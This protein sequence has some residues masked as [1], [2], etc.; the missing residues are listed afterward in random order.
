MYGLIIY[1]SIGFVRSKF[2]RIYACGLPIAASTEMTYSGVVASKNYLCK[3]SS[4]ICCWQWSA[5]FLLLTNCSMFNRFSSPAMN[6]RVV[7]FP[8]F[9]SATK[10]LICPSS[11]E[12]STLLSARLCCPR[13]YVI[14]LF[15]LTLDFLSL[16]ITDRFDILIVDLPGFKVLILVQNSFCKKKKLDMPLY[17]FSETVYEYHNYSNGIAITP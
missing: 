14:G 3:S 4:I 5:F 6:D 2:S 7:V 17:P 15:S 10:A 1:A 16:N 13:A 8:E 9:D 11:S 12:K